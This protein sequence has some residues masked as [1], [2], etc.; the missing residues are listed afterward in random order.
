[1]KIGPPYRGCAHGTLREG[2][3]KA[4]IIGINYDTPGSP[5]HAEFEPL[6]GP[7]NDAQDFRRLLTERYGYAS[8]DVTIMLDGSESPDLA[9]T[10]HNIITQ[11][12]KLVRGARPGDR[13]VFLY[14][15]HSGQIAC[16]EHSED[17]D[18]D[19]VILPMDHEGLEQKD[20]L[21]VDNDLRRLLVN[22]LPAGAYLTAIFDSCH[23]GTLL[24][25]EHY[26]CNN[27]YH[28]WISKGDRKMRSRWM[29]N[30][31]RDATIQPGVRVVRRASTGPGVLLKQLPLEELESSIGPVQPSKALSGD[32]ASVGGPR[33]R[34]STTAAK[35]QPQAAAETSRGR[36]LS[37]RL[38]ENI[39]ARAGT[40]LGLHIPRCM[41][42]ESLSRECDGNCV[43]SPTEKPHVISLAACSDRQIDWED[44]KG[45]S[46]TQMLIKHLDKNPHPR[47]GELMTFISYHRYD[48]SRAVHAVGRRLMKKGKKLQEE[49]ADAGAISPSGAEIIQVPVELVNFQDPQLGS[50]EKLNM[51]AV[52][53]F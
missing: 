47:I 14:S 27:I 12:E 3:K 7:R 39:R 23:S 44:K 1:M 34:S 10:R 50:R 51:D 30:V 16:L 32:N 4:L 28:P 45:G 43:A 29:H 38:S 41:S 6:A 18:L 37:I 5:T 22:P 9:P 19:E 53:T 52:F 49:R 40:V 8:H 26:N 36:R 24:D 31:R 46:M 25:L 48:A 11:I 33:K 2:A 13:F 15:G 42:P 21:I 20:K 35:S 17:D